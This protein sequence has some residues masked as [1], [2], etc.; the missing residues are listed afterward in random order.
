MLRAGV[1]A[2]F[3]EAPQAF[4]DL[5]NLY[6]PYYRQRNLCALSGL[7]HRGFMEYQYGVQRTDV[8]AALDYYFAHYNQGRPFILA[9]YSQGSMMIKIALRD[10]FLEHDDYSR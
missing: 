10:Y 2:H 9:G 7:D 8:Y 1:M 3:N 6:E 5:T 4:V